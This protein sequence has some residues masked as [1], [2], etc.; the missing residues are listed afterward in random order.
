MNNAERAKRVENQEKERSRNETKGQYEIPDAKCDREFV[1]NF[2]NEGIAAEVVKLLM[3]K[4]LS[5]MEINEILYETD[6][7]FRNRTLEMKLRYSINKTEEEVSDGCEKI[8]IKGFHKTMR[9]MEQITE[10]AKVLR[11]EI[12]RL[13]NELEKTKKLCE[14]GKTPVDKKTI[15]RLREYFGRLQGYTDEDFEN[16]KA[17]QKRKGRYY[18]AL[19]HQA[20]NSIAVPIF[21]SIFRKI[22]K[23]EVRHEDVRDMQTCDL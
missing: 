9:K 1:S 19:Y 3:S 5:Y 8:G 16:A 20:G 10:Q 7:A 22:I 13:N 6:K 12:E 14:T 2:K 23:G 15:N 18:T 17:V 11:E 21:E 4:N